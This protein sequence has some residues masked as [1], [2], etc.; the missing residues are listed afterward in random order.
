MEQNSDNIVL[1]RAGYE[2]L[3]RE[4]D[5]LLSEESVELAAQLMDAQEDEDGEEAVFFDAMIAKDRLHERVSYLKYVLATAT[6]LDEDPDPERVSPGNRVTVWDVAEEEELIFD[7]LGGAEVTSGRRGVSTDSP[8]GKAL[9]GQKVGDRVE[10]EVP[11][12]TAS[13]EIRKIERVPEED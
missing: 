3:K 12:G 8:V 13:Y 11:I 7:I 1:T 2:K 10:V 9:L 6:V 5:G 4:L